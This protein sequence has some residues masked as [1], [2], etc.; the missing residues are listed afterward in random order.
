[1]LDSCHSIKA[2]TTQPLRLLR[3]LNSESFKLNAQHFLSIKASFSR[4]NFPKCTVKLL[5]YTARNQYSFY[6]TLIKISNSPNLE[7]Q[8]THSYTIIVHTNTALEMATNKGGFDFYFRFGYRSRREACTRGLDSRLA[9]WYRASERR[10]PAA[11]NQ[12]IIHTE[13]QHPP[14]TIPIENE[15]Y[16]SCNKAYI[17]SKASCRRA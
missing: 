4:H 16:I 5:N 8:T 10:L 7:I 2:L 1:M 17:S 15:P 11:L 6:L 13:T 14:S 12:F 3:I 9:S